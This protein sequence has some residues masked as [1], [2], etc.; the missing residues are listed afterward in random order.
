MNASGFLTLLFVSS[1]VT[2]RKLIADSLPRETLRQRNVGNVLY[3]FSASE[4]EDKLMFDF[5]D[6]IF[7][8]E[9]LADKRADQLLK[10]ILQSDPTAF[11]V[12]MTSMPTM[13]HITKLME[14]GTKGVIAKPFTPG[15]I[16][17][18]IQFFFKEKYKK[19]FAE[20]EAFTDKGA[21]VVRN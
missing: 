7:I 20:V 21:V 14:L 12:M 6:I 4:A 1:N 9:E 11:V 10:D 15:S 2:T 13:Q 19:S 16:D 8:D 18:Y 3:S 17:R 5:P